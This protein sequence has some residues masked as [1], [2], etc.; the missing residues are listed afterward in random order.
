M[1]LINGTSN[2]LCPDY[3]LDA[4]WVPDYGR[5]RHA[6]EVQVS[7]LKTTAKQNLSIHLTGAT[8]MK[9]PD[10]ELANQLLAFMHSVPHLWNWDDL[11]RIN[12]ARASHVEYRGQEGK[13]LTFL[14]EVLEIDRDDEGEYAHV[15]THIC[16]MREGKALGSVYIPLSGSVFIP[17][18]GNVEYSELG[19]GAADKAVNMKFQPTSYVGG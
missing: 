10:T 17:R 4:G 7:S 16:D 6:F 12:S 14:L 9:F 3:I 2:I 8:K 13:G 15:H 5:S 18:N 11:V 1:V 19:N